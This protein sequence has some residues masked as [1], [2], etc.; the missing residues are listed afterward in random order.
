MSYPKVVNTIT[1]G[2]NPKGVSSDGTNV[3]VTNSNSSNVSQISC[4]S[5]NVVKTITVGSNPQGVSSDGTNVWVTNSN[6]SSSVSQI[7][8]SSGNVVKTITLGSNPQGV[9]SDGTNVWVSNYGS[10]NVSQIQ[11]YDTNTKIACFKEGS[12]IFTD[13]GYLPIEFLKKGDFVKTYLHGYLPIVLIGKSTIYN[14]GNSERIKN[15]LYTLPKSN[16]PLLSEDL[17]LTGCHSLLVDGLYKGQIED[18]GKDNGI[19]YKTDD[20]LRLF[21]C[22]EPRAIP[23]PEEGIFTI[24]H[25]ALESEYEQINFGVWANG[26]LVET[27]SIYDIKEYSTMEI[28]E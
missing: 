1:V 7:S 12:K 3:W 4:S 16:F 20:K 17:V 15:R 2:S 10:N 27:I 14:S 6:T 11:I 9:S 18:M 22:F 28:M 21:T 26:L 5:G 8:C 25:I 13:K 24:Y 19:L 23:Y